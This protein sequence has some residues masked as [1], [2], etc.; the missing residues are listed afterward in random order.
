[1]E[2]KTD[3]IWI[4]IPN[5]VWRKELILAQIYINKQW[6]ETY[7]KDPKAIFMQIIAASDMTKKMV[8][9]FEN[10]QDFDTDNTPKTSFFKSLFLTIVPTQFFIFIVECMK[11]LNHKSSLIP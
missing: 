4:W 2:K 1:M 3:S 7:V 9:G 11:I 5:D 8:A 10:A 6:N